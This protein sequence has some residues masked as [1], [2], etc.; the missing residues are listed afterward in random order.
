MRECE[1]PTRQ[2]KQGRPFPV[3]PP[4]RTY[5]GPVTSRTSRRHLG[6]LASRAA[7]LDVLDWGCGTAEYRPLIEA[8]GHR[9]VGVDGAGSGADVLVD[10]HSLPFAPDAFD[11]V[12]TNAVLEHV[13]NPFLAMREV[14][15]VLKRDGIRRG[16]SPSWSRTITDRTS[17]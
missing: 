1:F 10:V 7:P 16:A 11:H 13:A 4:D 15:R 2:V 8:L 14:A 6:I 5:T 12:I 17:T 3:D 9:Y